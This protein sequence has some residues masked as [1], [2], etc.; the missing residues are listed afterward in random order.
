M[1]DRYNELS[2]QKLTHI[3]Q[4]GIQ[5][6]DLLHRDVENVSFEGKK[7]TYLIENG[8]YVAGEDIAVEKYHY[9]I[10]NENCYT[11]VT[12]AKDNKLIVHSVITSIE[13]LPWVFRNLR[14]KNGDVLLLDGNT[15]GMLIRV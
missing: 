4:T 15:K 10:I 14:L 9:I 13:E 12:S 3:Q 2:E 11:S 8:N 6:Q 7:A 1:I 5:L